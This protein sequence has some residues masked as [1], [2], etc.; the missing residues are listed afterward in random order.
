[1]VIF[2]GSKV[3]RT[4]RGGKKITIVTSDGFETFHV[5]PRNVRL[6]EELAN[7]WLRKTGIE[8]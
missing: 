3:E 2:N 7:K 5:S 6:I 4:K 1:M 8:P